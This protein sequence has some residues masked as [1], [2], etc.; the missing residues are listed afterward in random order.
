MK[1]KIRATSN[2][3]LCSI[4]RSLPN[5]EKALKLDQPVRITEYAPALKKMNII[6]LGYFVINICLSHDTTR[7]HLNKN[8]INSNLGLILNNVEF[9]QVGSSSVFVKSFTPSI[10]GCNVP[11]NVTLFGP[12]RI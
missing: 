12:N 10:I 5:L 6:S 8:I 1:V 9:L 7:A 3:S 11:L 4:P 2:E